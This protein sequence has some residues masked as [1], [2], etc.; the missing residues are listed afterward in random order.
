MMRFAYQAYNIKHNLFCRSD[1]VFTPHP[2]V[3]AQ[4]LMR[5]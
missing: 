5:R 4:C 2:A 1:K 3:G